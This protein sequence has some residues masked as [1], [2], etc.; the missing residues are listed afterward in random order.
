MHI[1]K[2]RD[3]KRIKNEIFHFSRIGC[4]DDDESDEDEASIEKQ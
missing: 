4:H 3:I 2:L 1:N